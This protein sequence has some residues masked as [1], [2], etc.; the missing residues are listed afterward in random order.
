MWE[1]ATGRAQRPAAHSGL[2]NRTWLGGGGG[3]GVWAGW[4]VWE[5]PAGD[6]A[7]ASPTVCTQEPVEDYPYPETFMELAACFLA[8][9]TGTTSARGGNVPFVKAEVWLDG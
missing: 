9:F 7:D 2:Y 6:P 1:G 3:G 4:L 5:R 8:L